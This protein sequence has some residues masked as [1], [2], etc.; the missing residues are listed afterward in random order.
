LTSHLDF[1][2]APP[3]F[4]CFHQIRSFY[5]FPISRKTEAQDVRTNGRTDGQTDGVQQLMRSPKAG[6]ITLTICIAGRRHVLYK[7]LERSGWMTWPLQRSTARQRRWLV[8]NL[9]VRYRRVFW[10]VYWP[11]HRRLLWSVWSIVDFSTPTNLSRDDVIHRRA[12][13]ISLLLLAP[14]RWRPT[15]N[16]RALDWMYTVK[17][18]MQCR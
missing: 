14:M 10:C 13:F 4:L 3:V 6:R 12:A 17:T 2:F 16:L 7:V 18:G 5:G 1:K 15:I 9:A 8:V 11:R